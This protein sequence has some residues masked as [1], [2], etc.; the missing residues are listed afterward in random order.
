MLLSTALRSLG[1]TAPLPRCVRAGPVILRHTS[2]ASGPEIRRIEM[3][4]LPRPVAGA[5]MVGSREADAKQR[6][7]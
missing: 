2:R 6:A 7:D 1:D 4:L 5:K 3:A